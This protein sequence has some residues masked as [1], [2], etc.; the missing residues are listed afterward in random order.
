VFIDLDGFK[1]VNDTFGHLAGDRLLA[2]SAGRLRNAMR[3]GD[4]VGRLGGDEFLILLPNVSDV[5]TAMSIA[6]RLGAEL[7]EPLDVVDGLP[8]NIRSSIGVAWSDVGTTT[9]D[10]LVAAADR[11]MY[12]CKRAGTNEPVLALV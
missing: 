8:V 3:S 10:V 2:R 6:T 12:E 9:A 7:A 1:E 4:T 5:D 11:A